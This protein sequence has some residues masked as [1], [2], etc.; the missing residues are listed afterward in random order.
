MANPKHQNWKLVASTKT[1]LEGVRDKT[2]KGQATSPSALRRELPIT[3][4]A[5]APTGA[6]QAKFPA[7]RAQPN[8][9]PK[10]CRETQTEKLQTQS[11]L[12]KAT[13]RI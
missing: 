10:P 4:W 7:G 8:Y 11:H 12:K 5:V 13:P 2:A 1:E 6:G 3:E 9:S